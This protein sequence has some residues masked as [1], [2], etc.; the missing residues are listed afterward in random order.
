VTR[1][2]SKMGTLVTLGAAAVGS[3]LVIVVNCIHGSKCTRIKCCG[4]ECERA[5]NPAGDI[6]ENSSTTTNGDQSTTHLRP[7]VTR[8]TRP[9]VQ[10][11]QI[12]A[13]QAP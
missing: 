13:S 3:L 6:E 11:D 1:D 4:F 10:N 9:A 5:V 8:P 12:R 2:T 7:E